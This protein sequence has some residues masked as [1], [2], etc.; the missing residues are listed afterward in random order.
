MDLLTGTNI[1]T[2]F[3]IWQEKREWAVTPILA[4]KLSPGH[5]ARRGDRENRPTQ[6]GVDWKIEEC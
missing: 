6:S 5:V 2:A 1:A 3:F 4:K